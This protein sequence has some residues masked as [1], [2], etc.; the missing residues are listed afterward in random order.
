MFF[1]SC[2]S[3]F[4]SSISSSLHPFSQKDTFLI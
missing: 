2:Q 1:F 4:S 3:C